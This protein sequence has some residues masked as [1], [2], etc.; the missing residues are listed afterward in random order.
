MTVT[1]RRCTL[2]HVSRIP[3][4]NKTNFEFYTAAL[5]CV[6]LQAVNTPTTAGVM[7]A[8]GGIRRA[9]IRA[10]DAAEDWVVAARSGLHAQPLVYLARFG[11]PHEYERFQVTTDRV[12]GGACACAAVVVVVLVDGAA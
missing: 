12:L 2:W 6:D 9:F 4:L 5:R 3:R 8:R 10:R 11:E 7:S 1:V